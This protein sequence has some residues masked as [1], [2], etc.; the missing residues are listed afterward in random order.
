[1]HDFS[2]S[3]TRFPAVWMLLS[4]LAFAEHAAFRQ[5]ELLLAQQ[6]NLTPLFARKTDTD[7]GAWHCKPHYSTILLYEGCKKSFVK[8][9]KA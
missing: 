2:D 8:L 3:S 5:A 4:R 1:M 7:D 6:H 9:Y